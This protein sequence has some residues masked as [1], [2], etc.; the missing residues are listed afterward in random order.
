VSGN[1][2]NTFGN[3]SSEWQPVIRHAITKT[4]ELL[5][6]GSARQKPMNTGAALADSGA[7][8]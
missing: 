6:G 2:Q 4:Q 8:G 5:Q 7:M 1:F 3:S